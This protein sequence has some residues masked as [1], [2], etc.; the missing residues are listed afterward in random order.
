MSQINTSHVFSFLEDGVFYR[1][2]WC[3]KRDRFAWVS[4]AVS[5]E[6]GLFFTLP[7]GQEIFRYDPDNFV[8]YS[9]TLVSDTP[10]FPHRKDSL[11]PVNSYCTVCFYNKLTETFHG[12]TT[13][14]SS[15]GS[16]FFNNFKD[17][18]DNCV[19]WAV[20]P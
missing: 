10:I 17:F 20:Q 5:S 14:V 12:E 13:T 6:D 18:T 16:L 4:S 7:D 8:F 15:Q 11:P 2:K 1:I 3:R 9:C 19:I